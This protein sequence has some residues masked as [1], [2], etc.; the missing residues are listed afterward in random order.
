MK[1]PGRPKRDMSDK[2]VARRKEIGQAI[3]SYR[4]EHGY[5]RDKFAALVG[6]S[7]PTIQRWENGTTEIPTTK[8][9]YIAS[10]IG[11]DNA[12][13]CAIGAV[14][15][16]N[17]ISVISAARIY[18]TEKGTRQLFN[19]D[20]IPKILALYGERNV[21]LVIAPIENCLEIIIE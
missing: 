9:E 2:A 15:V 13:K 20:M 19:I 11:I 17:L 8:F 6:S 14:K 7:R 4:K 10:L 5:S 1:R 18:I 21:H 16:K 3:K 12:N